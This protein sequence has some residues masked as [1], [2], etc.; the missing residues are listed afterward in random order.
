MGTESSNASARADTRFVAPGPD[1]A[2]HT[3]AFPVDRAYPEAANDS[4]CSCL[5]RWFSIMGDLVSAWWISM[6]APPGY[7]KTSVTP[8]LSSASTSIS[9]PFRGS[10]GERLR[11]W[12]L[13]GAV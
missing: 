3:P 5:R 9:A 4:P 10:F 6:E 2:T 11:T 1:V 7:A 8:S 13:G 12:R